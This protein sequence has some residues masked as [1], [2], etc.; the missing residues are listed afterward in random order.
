VTEF[1]RTT[2]LGQERTGRVRYLA[3]NSVALQANLY[4]LS[5]I[6]TTKSDPS[7]TIAMACE[8]MEF[9]RGSV[10]F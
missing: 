8:R 4:H 10:D 7:L 6:R 9:D 2:S 3:N 1:L 5:L